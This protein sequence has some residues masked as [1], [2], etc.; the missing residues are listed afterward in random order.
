MYST[1]LTEYVTLRYV[2]PLPKNK[3]H[4]NKE[5]MNLLFTD[6]PTLLTKSVFVF[7]RGLSCRLP[8][9]KPFQ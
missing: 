7:H 5:S 8:K 4:K 6:K 3:T 2:A 9:L 1:Y